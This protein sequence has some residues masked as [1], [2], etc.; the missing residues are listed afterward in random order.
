MKKK[1][2]KAT[3]DLISYCKLLKYMRTYRLSIMGDW[4][5]YK[6]EYK[7]IVNNLFRPY[8]THSFSFRKNVNYWIVWTD[9]FGNNKCILESDIEEV[10]L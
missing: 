1:E 3:K 9:I 8:M 2:S 10:K 7:R 5:L 6:S 4:L